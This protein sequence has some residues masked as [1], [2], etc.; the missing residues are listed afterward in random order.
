[1]KQVA[2]LVYWQTLCDSKFLGST[3]GPVFDS[4]DASADG[5]EQ[6]S[7]RATRGRPSRARFS[8]RSTIEGLAGINC[9]FILM[10]GYCVKVNS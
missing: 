6:R 9:T 8:M 4:N 3:E 5:S 10:R 7:M 1:M 2:R